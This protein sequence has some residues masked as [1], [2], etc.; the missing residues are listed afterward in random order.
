MAGFRKVVVVVVVVTTV[1]VEVVVVVA[2][3]LLMEA[4]VSRL[5][6]FLLLE[7]S[8]A[9]VPM[10]SNA[11]RSLGNFLYLAPLNPSTCFLQSLLH[12]QI[13]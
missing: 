10:K 12:N 11:S 6:G 5:I 9:V 3:L 13:S 7:A 1:L 4:P 2:F 8:D